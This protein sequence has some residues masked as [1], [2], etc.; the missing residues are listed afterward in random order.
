MKPSSLSTWA[1]PT[2]TLEAGMVNCLRLFVLALRRRVQKSAIG[3]VIMGIVLS[4]PRGLAHAGDLAAVRGGTQADA[5]DAELAVDRAL[6]AAHRATGVGARRE[7]RLR[8]A[9]QDPGQ[10]GHRWVLLLSSAAAC[11]A[12]RP[13]GAGRAFRARAGVRNRVRRG[14]RW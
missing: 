5:A 1:I 14:P 2:F 10:L 6:A 11:A 8:L 4:S 12:D 3:S 9:L 13:R 7:L